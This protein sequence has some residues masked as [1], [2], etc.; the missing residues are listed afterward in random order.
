[1]I[2]SK[3]LEEYGSQKIEDVKLDDLKD[4]T[5]VRV[6]PERSV[7]ERVLSFILQ[8]DNP[9]LFKVGETPVKVSFSDD[10]LTL[11]KSLEAIFTK[12]TH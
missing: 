7:L 12:N 9:Y 1:M 4:I 3:K 8:I 6:N 10:A 5:T 2:T 11:Q